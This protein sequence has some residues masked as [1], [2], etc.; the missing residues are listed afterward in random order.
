MTTLLMPLKPMKIIILMIWSKLWFNS[1][2]SYPAF[3]VLTFCVAFSFNGGDVFRQF[4]GIFEEI[5][6]WN[7]FVVLSSNSKRYSSWGK[8]VKFNFFV[9]Y[10][11]FFSKSVVFVLKR[12]LVTKYGYIIYWFSLHFCQNVGNVSKT[13]KNKRFWQN[14]LIFPTFPP[15]WRNV[16]KISKICNL[17]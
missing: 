4:S 8:C 1:L 11:Y 6:S 3:R 13:S 12:R 9:T 17:I 7:S 2:L 14:L 16:G 10:F 5:F 15:I